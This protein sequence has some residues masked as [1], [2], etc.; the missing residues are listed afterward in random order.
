MSVS[1]QRSWLADE[2]HKLLHLC[3][4]EFFVRE[5]TKCPRSVLDVL[6]EC[7]SIVITPET[8]LTIVSQQHPRYYSISSSS[9]VC[10]S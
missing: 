10:L 5:V 6:R 9:N 1:I 8:F 4:K 2:R 3:E 7:P